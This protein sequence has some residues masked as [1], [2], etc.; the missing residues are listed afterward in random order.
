MALAYRQG[1][2]DY[3]HLPNILSTFPVISSINVRW[4]GSTCL[5]WPLRI[6]RAFGITVICRTYS[7]PFQ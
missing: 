4:F 5:A 2:R 7:P 3:G 1:V 6:A